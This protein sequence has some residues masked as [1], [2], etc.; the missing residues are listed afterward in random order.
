MRSQAS[1]PSSR[2]E[3]KSSIANQY[4]DPCIITDNKVKRTG[5]GTNIHPELIR[6]NWSQTFQRRNS[7]D[8][9]PAGWVKGSAR[10]D[11]EHM[12]HRERDSDTLGGRTYNFYVHQGA[13]TYYSQPK[14]PTGEINA[15]GIVKTVTKNPK[16]FAAMPMRHSMISGLSDRN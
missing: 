3:Q 7:M 15:Y 5:C 12:C 13:T 4:G 14:Q 8:P 9:C 2:P 6:E 1:P 16:R 11:A 10:G